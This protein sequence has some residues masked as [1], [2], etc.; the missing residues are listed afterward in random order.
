MCL[1]AVFWSGVASLVTGATKDDAEAIGYDEGPVFPA[2]YEYLERKGMVVIREV[3]RAE[4]REL[5]TAY[6]AAGGE[7][8]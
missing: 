4:A 1:G 6:V 3:M 7:I 2:S 8:Y 5:F